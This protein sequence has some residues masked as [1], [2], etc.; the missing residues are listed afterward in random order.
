MRRPITVGNLLDFP[1]DPGCTSATDRDE[2]SY[3]ACSNGVDDDQDG[4]TDCRFRR[5]DG[6][7][8]HGEGLADQIIEKDRKR[9]EIDA[10]RQ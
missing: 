2:I 9:H 3:P 8:K 5:S 4:K 6:Q 1:A 10:D 7:D